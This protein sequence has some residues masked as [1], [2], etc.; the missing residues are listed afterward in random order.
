MAIAYFGAS[1]STFWLF[2]VSNFWMVYAFVIMYGIC[3]G[4]RVSALLGLLGDFFG[5]TNLAQLIGIVSGVGMGIGGFGPYIAGFL[6]DITG[7]YFLPFAFA[8][9]SLALGGIIISIIRA[10]SENTEAS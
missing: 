9:I 1:I 5:T 8:A 6:Y 2:G 10:P 7:S 3:H 4:G